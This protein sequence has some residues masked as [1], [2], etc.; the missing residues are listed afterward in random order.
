MTCFVQW[1]VSGHEAGC[2]PAEAL[3]VI[4]WFGSGSPYFLPSAMRVAGPNRGDV[5][6]AELC[7]NVTL[8]VVSH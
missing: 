2:V 7:N 8:F 1:G 5:P 3:S 4:M 6:T